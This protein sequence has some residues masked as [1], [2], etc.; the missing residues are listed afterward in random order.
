MLKKCTRRY[1]KKFSINFQKYFGLFSIVSFLCSTFLIFSNQSFALNNS[2]GE[3]LFTQHCSG[4]HINGGN[5]IRRNK[6]LKMSALIRNGIESPEEIA[7][8]AKFGIG[9]MDG[10]EKFLEK[11]GD[12]IVAN[13]IWEQAQK[14]W[15]QG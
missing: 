1:L 6:T 14:A 3:K 13:W 9:S 15:V 4:C 2:Q 12:Q 5:I 8:I 11:D 10:Y 7:K